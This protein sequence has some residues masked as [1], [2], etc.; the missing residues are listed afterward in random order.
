MIPESVIPKGSTVLLTGA[1][2]YIASHIADQLISAGYKVKGTVR[3]EEKGSLIAEAL[4][5]RHDTK[6]AFSYV[7]VEEMSA[8]NAF[9]DAI[10]G[11]QCILSDD[12]RARTKVAKIS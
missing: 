8:E 7:V 4:E 6:G 9:D 2:G 12:C 1:N 10:K 11:E 5:K 3:N